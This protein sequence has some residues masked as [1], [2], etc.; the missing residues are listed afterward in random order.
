MLRVN[1]KQFFRDRV[2]FGWWCTIN[3]ERQWRHSGLYADCFKPVQVKKNKGSHWYL[4]QILIC[5]QE[6]NLNRSY[7]DCIIDNDDKSKS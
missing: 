3:P 4:Q 1:L 2:W 7:I 6:K 5:G